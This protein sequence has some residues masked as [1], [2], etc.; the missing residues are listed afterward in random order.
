MVQ[1]TKLK[2][3]PSVLVRLGEGGGESIQEIHTHGHC[4]ICKQNTPTH[5]Y[6]A[7]YRTVN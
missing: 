2:C 1:H 7:M 4:H 5:Y 6:I 3:S